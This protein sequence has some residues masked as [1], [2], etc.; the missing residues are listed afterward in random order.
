M[1]SRT[2][3]RQLRRVYK[4]KAATPRLKDG[5]RLTDIVTTIPG[6][7]TGPLGAFFLC[8]FTL[9]LQH[10]HGLPRRAGRQAECELGRGVNQ[11]SI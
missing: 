7:Q 2:Q 9:Q 11:N 5:F 3:L 10:R 8:S 4:R 1:L 6:L